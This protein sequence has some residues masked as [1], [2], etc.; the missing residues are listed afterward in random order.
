MAQDGLQR[1]GGHGLYFRA[2]RNI[3]K[4]GKRNCKHPLM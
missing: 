1:I 3:I 2:A 4:K